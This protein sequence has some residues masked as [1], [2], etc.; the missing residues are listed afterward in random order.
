MSGLARSGAL[1]AVEPNLSALLGRDGDQVP[2]L[3]RIPR[4]LVPDVFFRAF[5]PQTRPI[6]RTR[7]DAQPPLG[8]GLGSPALRP[9][10][11]QSRH[12][13][14]IAARTIPLRGA[15]GFPAYSM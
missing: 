12:A 13:R 4:V 2:G 11:A 1:E 9:L 15:L 7:V 6:A 14:R 10:L 5:S 8:A 3:A